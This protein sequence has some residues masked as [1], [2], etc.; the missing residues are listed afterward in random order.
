[1][2]NTWLK[3]NNKLIHFM[4]VEKGGERPEGKGANGTPRLMHG[5][6]PGEY[7]RKIIFYFQIP[8]I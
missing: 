1:M 6:H 3:K 7:K 2:D 8:T 5:A 4:G